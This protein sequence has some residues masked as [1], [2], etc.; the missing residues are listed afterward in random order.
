MSG[1]YYDQHEAVLLPHDHLARHRQLVGLRSRWRLTG[2]AC[3]W[4]RLIGD[5]GDLGPT[6]DGLGPGSS[7]LGGGHSVTA[8]VEEGVD[9]VVG[10]EEALCLAG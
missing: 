8:E 2:A 5:A 4:L 1:T 6:P 9:P 3:S 10:G 7:I